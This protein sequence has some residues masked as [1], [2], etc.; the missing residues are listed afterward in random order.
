VA[1]ATEAFTL[2]KLGNTA[3]TPLLDESSGCRRWPWVMARARCLAAKLAFLA[4]AAA[5]DVR[6]AMV[7]RSPPPELLVA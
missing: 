6:N 3:A 5:R 1:R 2:V 4:G 7:S